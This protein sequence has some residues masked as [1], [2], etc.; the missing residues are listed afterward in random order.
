MGIGAPYNADRAG[1]VRVF[2][3]VDG[4]WSQLGSDIDGRS[5]GDFSN[6]VALSDDGR[7]VATGAWWSDGNGENS[8]C[9]RVFELIKLIPLRMA[10]TRLEFATESGA[11]YTLLST[12]NLTTGFT[13]ATNLIGNGQTNS[14]PIN[15]NDDQR[16]YRCSETMDD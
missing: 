8:G 12:T 5:A 4:D 6:Y 7:I 16:F 1:N 13:A 2:Q 15:F 11:D 14:V 10:G 9:V 3:H